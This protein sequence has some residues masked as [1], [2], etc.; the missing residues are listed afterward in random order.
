MLFISLTKRGELGIK[1]RERVP[2]LLAEDDKFL[3]ENIS[4]FLKEKNFTVFHADNCREA[5]KILEKFTIHIALID[6]KL[7]DGDGTSIMD[8]IIENKFKTKMIMMTAYGQDNLIREHI[9]KGTFDF[10]EKPF[11]LDTLQKRLDNAVRMYELEY[12]DEAAEI[13]SRSTYK[14]IGESDKTKNIKKMISMVSQTNSSVLIQGETGTGKELIARN[15]HLQSDRSKNQFISIN[16][17]SIPENLFESEFFGYE[18]GAFTGAVKEKKGLFEI[19]NFGILHLDEIGEMPIE[20]QAKLLRVLEEGTFIKLGGSKEIK[21]D[22]RIIATTNKNLLEEIE[23]K[24]FREDLYFRIAVFNIYVHPLRE[25]SEDI[26]LIAKHLWK[27]LVISMGKNIP[28]P[29]IDFDKLTQLYW[30]GNV[31]ELRNYLENHLI[32][33]GHEG[34]VLFSEWKNGKGFDKISPNTNLLLEDVIKDHILK[35]LKHSNYNKTKAAKILG[36]GLSTLKRK[37]KSWGL[38]DYDN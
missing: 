36:I 20:F 16:C 27:N 15:I 19:A 21:V 28:E 8:S 4:E 6:R 32:Y 33:S 3:A 30:K 29:D 23:K 7:R 5:K 13:Y 25:R 35:V 31:R 12:T 17:A 11:N 10:L 34:E 18:K 22:V 26:P 14:I 9:R 2:I 1:Q 37:L 24:K 38:T